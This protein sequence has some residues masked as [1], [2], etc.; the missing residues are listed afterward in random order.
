MQCRQKK[1]WSLGLKNVYLNDVLN[2][3][4]YSRLIKWKKKPKKIS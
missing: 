1:I 3:K 4:V 2:F